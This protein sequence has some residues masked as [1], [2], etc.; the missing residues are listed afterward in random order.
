MLFI[1]EWD[2]FQESCRNSVGPGLGPSRG[3]F[4]PTAME[5]QGNSPMQ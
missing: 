3:L 2:V 5:L 4:V 1:I